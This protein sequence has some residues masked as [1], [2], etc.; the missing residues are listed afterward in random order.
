MCDLQN[1]KAEFDP[2]EGYDVTKEVYPSH[3]LPGATLKGFPMKPYALLKSRYVYVYVDLVFTSLIW[4]DSLVWSL[5]VPG[6]EPCCSLAIAIH[7]DTCHAGKQ[8]Y[9]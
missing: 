5:H 6:Q 8:M 1:L 7:G 4:K 9:V 2:L 3:H